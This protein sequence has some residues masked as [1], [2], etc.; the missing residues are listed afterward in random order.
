MVERVLIFGDSITQGLWDRQGGWAQR[1]IAD[2]L[3]Q[4]IDNLEADTPLLF[5]L[6]I[7]ADTTVELLARFEHEAKLRQRPGMAFVFAIGTNDTRIDGST[8]FSTPEQ[9]AANLELLITKAK[10]FNTSKLLCVGLQPC[11]EARTTPVSWRDTTYT[12]ERL[13]LFDQTL[14]ETCTNL[15]VAYVS[16]FDAYQRRQTTEGTMLLDGLH[17]DDAGHRPDLRAS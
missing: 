3:A 11:D 12:N 8:P 17:P 5:N 7:S 15:G 16:I 10:Q 9:Y 6:G 4:A 1:L 2:Y 14:Q 13:K